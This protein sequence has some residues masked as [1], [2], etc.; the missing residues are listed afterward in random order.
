MAANYMLIHCYQDVLTSSSTLMGHIAFALNQY[1][2]HEQVIRDYMK[3]IRTREEN[4]DELRRR[5]RT[6]MG[7]G[8]LCGEEVDKNEPR[9]MRKA[10][11][12]H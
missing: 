6:V 3:A 1:A 12:C 8:G 7:E 2:N 11:L 5:R 9:G 10:V 4:L